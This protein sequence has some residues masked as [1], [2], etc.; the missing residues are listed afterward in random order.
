[1]FEGHNIS[2]T[3]FDSLKVDYPE[4]HSKFWG[5]LQMLLRKMLAAALSGGGN[6]LPSSQPALSSYVSGDTVKLREI[7]G[8]S[9]KSS[10][11]RQ[12]DAMYSLWI[13]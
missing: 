6:K 1:M 2:E 10:D 12:F 13:S 11:F 7:Y 9:L 3:A 8:K 5:Q 4:L